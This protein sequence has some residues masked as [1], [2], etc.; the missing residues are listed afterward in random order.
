MKYFYS[1]LFIIIFSLFS[2]GQKEATK[3][4]EREN[5]LDIEISFKPEPYSTKPVQ[6]KTLIE[7]YNSIDEGL[8]GSPI[9]PSKTYFVAIPPSSKIEVQLIDQKYNLITNSEIALNP[10]VTFSTDSILFYQD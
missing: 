3:V 7:F 1:I 6:N 2:F 10:Q 4:F 9:L 5:G 8:P